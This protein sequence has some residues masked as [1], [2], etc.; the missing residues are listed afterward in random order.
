MFL[1]RVAAEAAY[2]LT[3]ALHE[4]EGHRPG[5]HDQFLED[6]HQKLHTNC[7]PDDLII[8]EAYIKFLETNNPDAYWGHLK[9][10]GQ[11]PWWGSGAGGAAAGRRAD[12]Y[13]LTHGEMVDSDRLGARS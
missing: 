1:G 6:W 8:A 5:I 7:A 10:N 13:I 11:Y 4:Q 9:A 2:K 12:G 3:V